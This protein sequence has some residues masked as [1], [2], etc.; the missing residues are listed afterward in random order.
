MAL[1]WLPDLKASFEHERFED[2]LPS[3]LYTN[4]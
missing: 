1:P 3:L 2:L 4:L